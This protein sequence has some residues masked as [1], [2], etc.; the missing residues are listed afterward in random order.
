MVGDS[1]T[2]GRGGRVP[3]KLSSGEN[4]GEETTV[5]ST[6]LSCGIGTCM[7]KKLLLYFEPFGNFV[8]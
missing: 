2:V 7:F 6:H 1:D 4:E 3:C 5:A 8:T